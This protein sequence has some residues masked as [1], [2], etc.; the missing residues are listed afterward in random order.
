MN[1]NLD[2]S[3]VDHRRRRR[4]QRPQLA[5]R[6]IWIV[7]N[8]ILHLTAPLNGILIGALILN[9][10]QPGHPYYVAIREFLAT[11]LL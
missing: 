5:K 10:V 2:I 6:T 11:W 9:W 3:T 8:L 4:R 7:C 1:L